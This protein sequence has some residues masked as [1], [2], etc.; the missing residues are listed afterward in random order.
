MTLS[1]TVPPNRNASWNTI[2]R[3]PS[4]SATEPSLDETWLTVVAAVRPAL[5]RLEA[6][7]IEPQGAV[8]D[9]GLAMDREHVGQLRELLW[10]ASPVS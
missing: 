9:A 10:R 5:A 7:L 6:L 4:V 3:W 8:L 2:A 1:R